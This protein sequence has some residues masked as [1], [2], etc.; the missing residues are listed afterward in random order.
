MIR[1]LKLVVGRDRQ[2][3][4]PQRRIDFRLDRLEIWVIDDLDFEW[5]ADLVAD[6]DL[7]LGLVHRHFKRVTAE[8]DRLRRARLT[9]RGHVERRVALVDDYEVARSVHRRGQ[10]RR[11]VVSGFRCIK[12]DAVLD[13]PMGT[14]CLGV[15]L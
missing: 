5:G 6:V 14:N 13:D 10:S 15:I 9:G 8:R 7:L 1:R 4:A 2:R 3:P 11:G 12:Y